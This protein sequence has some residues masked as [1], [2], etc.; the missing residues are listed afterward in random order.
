MT[1]LAPG[2]HPIGLIWAQSEGGVIGLGGAMPWHVPEDLAHFTAITLGTPVIMGRNTW[3]SLSPRF[4]PLP[5]RR[6]IVITRQPD[7]AAPG[8]DV[9]HSLEAALELAAHELAAH[10]LAAPTDADRT[11]VIGGA[12]VYREAIALADRLEVTEIN[13]H[14]EG[15][16]YAPAVDDSWIA[17]SVEPAAG[18]HTSRTGV[19]YRFLRYERA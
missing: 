8:A 15:D 5:G 1:G 17:T 2:G 11:W 6:N 3:N 14:Y 12:Q 7:W 9:A 4:R 16:A 19:E 13:A 18:W 10:E